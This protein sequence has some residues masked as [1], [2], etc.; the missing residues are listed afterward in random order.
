MLLTQLIGERS[1]HLADQSETMIQVVGKRPRLS[2]ARTCGRRSDEVAGVGPVVRDFGRR[3]VA[4]HVGRTEPAHAGSVGEV[5]V[6]RAARARRMKPSILP[7][8]TSAD[9]IAFAMR[10]AAATS[11]LSW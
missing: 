7:V 8:S 10:P 3:V 4:H 2:P 1:R 5:H 6:L 11:A 9:R